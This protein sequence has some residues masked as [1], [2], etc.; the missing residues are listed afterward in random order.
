[1]VP[2]FREQGSLSISFYVSK[3]IY[4]TPGFGVGQR[5]VYFCGSQKILYYILHE[6]FLHERGCGKIKAAVFFISLQFNP[7]TASFQRES[8][9][10]LPLCES[11]PCRKT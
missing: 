7:M 3:Q 10:C 11:G 1:M 6:T 8:G 5:F 9:P 4:S 2:R